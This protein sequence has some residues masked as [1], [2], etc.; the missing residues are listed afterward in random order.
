MDRPCVCGSPCFVVM[1]VSVTILVCVGVVV[2]HRLVACVRI[3]LG[4]VWLARETRFLPVRFLCF[5]PFFISLRCYQMCV[6]VS[7]LRTF[8]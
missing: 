6:P 8:L 4:P 5:T 7:M 2:R 3:V 1:S